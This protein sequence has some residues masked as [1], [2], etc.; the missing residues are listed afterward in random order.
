MTHI[1]ATADNTIRPGDR[2]NWAYTPRGGY[3]YTQLIAA[4]VLKTSGKKAT[5]KVAIKLA[6]IWRTDTRNVS[7]EKLTPRTIYCPE[8][9]E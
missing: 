5:I 3:G 7:I 8:L 4:V 1:T 9:G 2:V 6:G